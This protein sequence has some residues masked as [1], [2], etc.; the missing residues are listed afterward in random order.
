MHK[1]RKGDGGVASVYPRICH[2]P[3][4]PGYS[5][6]GRA[7]R[8]GSEAPP[9]SQTPFRARTPRWPGL[10]VARARPRAQEANFSLVPK[11][12]LGTPLALRETPFRAPT[13]SLALVAA[14][15]VGLIFSPVLRNGFN[16]YGYMNIYLNIYLKI[17]LYLASHL[18]IL[19]LALCLIMDATETDSRSLLWKCFDLSTQ[20]AFWVF[21]SN[22]I[23]MCYCFVETF[24]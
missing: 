24:S 23:I 6:P 4:G 14:I 21:L 2:A 13:P 11:L 19:V 10:L 18:P 1:L 17:Y 12:H 8:A 15:V 5:L 3:G 9:R 22:I 20:A 7:P 16:G